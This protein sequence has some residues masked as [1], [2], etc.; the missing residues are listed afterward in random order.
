VLLESDPEIA[1]NQ[2]ILP[3]AET[4]SRSH[5]FRGLSAAEETRY[6]R[7]FEQIVTG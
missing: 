1:A 4:L 3:S 5:I 2:L 6:N 7:K